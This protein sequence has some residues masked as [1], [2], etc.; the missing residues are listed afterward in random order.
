MN[1]VSS[2][3]LACLMLILVIGMCTLVVEEWQE[4]VG[5][6]IAYKLLLVF[7][8]IAFLLFSFCCYCYSLHP[9]SSF[10]FLTHLLF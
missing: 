6:K 1:T 7:F 10:D 8:Y 3:V 5:C 2:I 4:A 9:C